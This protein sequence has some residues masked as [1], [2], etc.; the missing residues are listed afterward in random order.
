MRRV[1][2]ARAPVVR[3][4]CTACLGVVGVSACVRHPGIGQVGP[5]DLPMISQSRECG[6]IVSLPSDTALLHIRLSLAPRDT[7]Q[8][9]DASIRIYDRERNLLQTFHHVATSPF[10]ILQLQREVRVEASQSRYAEGRVT[11]VLSGG[12][13]HIVTF[14]LAKLSS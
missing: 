1:C 12:C 14:V 8:R 3:W 4:L 5:T 10:L 6:P 9:L 2:R 7:A 13:T 11:V